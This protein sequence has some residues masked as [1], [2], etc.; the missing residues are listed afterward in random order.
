MKQAAYKSSHCQLS[1]YLII[2]FALHYI[3]NGDIIAWRINGQQRQLSAI[4]IDQ[5][6]FCYIFL[7]WH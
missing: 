6:I 2:L 7:G 4:S 3:R 5:N 1:L